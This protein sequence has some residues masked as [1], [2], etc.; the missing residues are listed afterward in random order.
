VPAPPRS[1]GSAPGRG[2]CGAASLAGWLTVGQHE[3]HFHLPPPLHV[4]RSVLAH[5]RTV[6]PVVG[7][8][9][10]HLPAYGAHCAGK[11]PL[12]PVGPFPML[13]DTTQGVKSLHGLLCALGARYPSRPV[14]LNRQRRRV[15]SRRSASKNTGPFFTHVPGPNADR[16]ETGHSHGAERRTA[17]RSTARFAS[18]IGPAYSKGPG[19]SRGCGVTGRA[20]ASLAAASHRAATLANEHPGRTEALGAASSALSTGLYR[21]SD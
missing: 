21:R 17:G 13:V 5:A 8:A 18:N 19:G 20:P 10:E 16:T 6:E 9:D 15:R 2:R 3:K 14:G 1:R 7:E 12:G 11:R 4:L